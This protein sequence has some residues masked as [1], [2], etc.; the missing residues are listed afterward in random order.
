MPATIET[1]SVHRDVSCAIAAPPN[2]KRVKCWGLV[3]DWGP[4]RD[5]KPWRVALAPQEIPRSEGAIAIDVGGGFACFVLPDRTVRCWGYGGWGQLGDAIASDDHQAAE[6]VDVP[7][8]HDVAQLALGTDHGCARTLHGEVLCW[9]GD[10]AGQLGRGAHGRQAGNA[11]APVSGVERAIDLATDWETTC[12]VRGDGALLCWGRGF[13]ARAKRVDFGADFGVRSVAMSASSVCAVGRDGSLR[14]SGKLG[15]TTLDRFTPIAVVH[16]AER[17]AVADEFACAIDHGRELRCFGSAQPDLSALHDVVELSASATHVCAR[18]GDGEIACFGDDRFGQLGDGATTTSL[19]NAKPVRIAL[20]GKADQLLL[21]GGRE[22]ARVGADVWC[23]VTR[24][25]RD[26]AGV[27]APL[28]ADPAS[29][30]KPHDPRAR[31]VSAFDHECRR[32]DEGAVLCRGARF[33]GARAR[34][35]HPGARFDGEEKLVD[36][37]RDLAVGRHHACIVRDD[38]AVV[39]W[40]SNDFAQCAA[41]VLDDVAPRLVE[42]IH[43]TV[44]VAVDDQATCARTAKGEVWCFGN[45]ERRKDFT[46]LELHRW[47]PTF[48]ALR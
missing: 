4:M 14:C 46:P 44:E 31:V 37:A 1:V 45:D 22:C 5:L 48:V 2:A 26:G 35:A 9:G 19:A 29:L 36:R 12:A 7:A 25:P 41:P 32:T 43:D 8:L 24:P 21:G 40:G 13:G 15:G 27:D 10:P 47:T 20:P 16:D 42:G 33:Q 6:P 17:V 30:P 23:F 18:R 11:V 28:R 3:G 38:G 39:C 34:L